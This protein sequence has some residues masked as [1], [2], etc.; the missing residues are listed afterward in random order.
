[1]AGGL[2]AN[3]GGRAGRR[4]RKTFLRSDGF[5][6]VDTEAWEREQMSK[7]CQPASTKSV[8]Q[9]SSL[10]W[11]W[12]EIHGKTLRS[13][14]DTYKRLL[15]VVAAMNDPK[16]SQF[17]ASH[18]SRYREAR[19]KVVK[20]GTLNR[21][22]CSLRAMFSE[23]ERLGEFSGPNPLARVRVLRIS[24]SE[25]RSLSIEE[26][27]RVYAECRVS[28]NPD[29][30]LVALLGYLTGARW[31]ELEALR[32][33]DLLDGAIRIRGESAKNGKIRVVPVDRTVLELVRGHG[34]AERLF[35]SCYAAFR[36]AIARAGVELQPGQMAHVLR[37]TFASGFLRRGG[38]LTELRDLLGHGSIAVTSRYLHIVPGESS[39]RSALPPVV[40]TWLTP[41]T[42]TA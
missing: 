12:Y 39:S 3:L 41:Q 17:G 19:L 30:W 38:S 2:I 37:H 32:R 1:V 40:D 22:L 15:S 25:L 33:N 36:S 5:R 21:E 29:L 27:E 34:K 13:G 18:W 14:D 9:L 16:V 11:R 23:L 10:V 8:E 20:A 7:G 24:Q 4:I 28:R 35:G 6:K 42:K 31:G 26:W